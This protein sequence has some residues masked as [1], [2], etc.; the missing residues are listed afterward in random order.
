MNRPRT[1]PS[2]VPRPAADGSGGGHLIAP[3]PALRGA[4]IG[5]FSVTGPSSL[6]ARRLLPDGGADLIFN[7]NPV[8]GEP[9]AAAVGVLTA[10]RTVVR[11]SSAGHEPSELPLLG[12]AFAPGAA[13]SWLG[14]PLNELRDQVIA[15]DQLWGRDSARLLETLH[16][17][18]T[19]RA[20]VDQLSSFLSSRRRFSST[21][22]EDWIRAG[23]H[24]I[25]TR[26][27]RLSMRELCAEIGVGERR[28]Q[29]SFRERVG[30]SPKE[31]ARIAR[32]HATLARLQRGPPRSWSERAADSGFADQAHMIR[33]FRRL[34]GQ[35]PAAYQPE[36]DV[37]DSFNT[38]IGA[39]Y[40][41]P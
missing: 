40:K 3:P 20:R 13:F 17:A 28:L 1:P 5:F 32:L 16:E 22:A 38:T 7:F 35:T 4:V 8:Q 14:V 37:S 10:A 9:D 39:P 18:S 11:R 21:A 19:L 15:L 41:C 26:R 34:A 27:G 36:P 12:V 23:V 31:L 24:V 33:E 25:R 29:R 6:G 30:L 2:E